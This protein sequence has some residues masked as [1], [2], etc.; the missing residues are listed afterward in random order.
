MNPPFIAAE[1]SRLRYL[2]SAS[3]FNKLKRKGKNTLLVTCDKQ[4]NSK[5]FV[6]KIVRYN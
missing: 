4:I 2:V 6:K 1:G 5:A 3:R